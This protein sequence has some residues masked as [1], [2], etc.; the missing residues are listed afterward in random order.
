MLDI[1]FIYFDKLQHK[2]FYS[3]KVLEKYGFFS[4]TF[5]SLTQSSEPRWGSIRHRSSFHVFPA[6][7]I[8]SSMVL[9]QVPSGLPRCLF[10][11]G[12]QDSASSGCRPFFMRRTRPNHIHHLLLPYIVCTFHAPTLSACLGVTNDE[13]GPETSSRLWSLIVIRGTWRPTAY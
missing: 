13:V 3:C 12:A 7:F 11:G 5:H 1:Y 6:V 4:K 8:S 2:L 10:P 9:R